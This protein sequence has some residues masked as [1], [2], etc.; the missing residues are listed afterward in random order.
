MQIDRN[1]VELASRS[2]SREVKKGLEN[3]KAWQAPFRRL[4]RL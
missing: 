2:L 3:G 4:I 1:D